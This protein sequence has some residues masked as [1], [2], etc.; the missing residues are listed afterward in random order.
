MPLG[1]S[2][3]AIGEAFQEISNDPVRY[4]SADPNNLPSQ[5]LASLIQEHKLVTCW[6]GHFGGVGGRA[7]LD[8]ADRVRLVAP[9]VGIADV[10]IVTCALACPTT[11]R[12]FSTDGPLIRNV[13]LRTLGRRRRPGWEILE[14]P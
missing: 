7:F 14:A 10:L 9:S 12:L 2:L 13:E 8:L 6:A 11:V 5:K 3:V 4:A 1:V